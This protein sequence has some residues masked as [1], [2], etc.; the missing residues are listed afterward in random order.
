MKGCT[1]RAL[2]EG[3]ITRTLAYEE[4]DADKAIV[5]LSLLSYTQAE[6]IAAGSGAQ[7]R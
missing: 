3:T 5:R 4:L 7:G 1:T 6:V 2:L